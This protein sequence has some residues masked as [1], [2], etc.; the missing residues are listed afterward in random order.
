MSDIVIRFLDAY[1][2]GPQIA[3]FGYRPAWNHQYIIGTLSKQLRLVD[4]KTGSVLASITLPYT[5][6]AAA[7]IPEIPSSIAFTPYDPDGPVF[8]LA[9]TASDGTIRYYDRT[10]LAVVVTQTQKSGTQGI[11]YASIAGIVFD[12][13][14]TGQIIIYDQSTQSVLATALVPRGTLKAALWVPPTAGPEIHYA[15]VE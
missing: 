7:V 1:S 12:G 6:I 2:V 5:A 4:L 15:C 10:T 9:I 14:A 8:Y 11:L 13:P 3:A